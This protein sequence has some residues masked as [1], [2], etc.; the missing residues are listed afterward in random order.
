MVMTPMS[1]AQSPKTMV[2]IV[3]EEDED[4]E[5]GEKL[6]DCR[7]SGSLGRDCVRGG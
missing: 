7:G 1:R 3:P 4:R 6:G 5:V 2:V